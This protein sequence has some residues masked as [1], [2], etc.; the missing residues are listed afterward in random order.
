MKP[1]VALNRYSIG[2]ICFLAGLCTWF[3]AALV[4]GAFIP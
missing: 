4:L 1:P 3:I 2:F